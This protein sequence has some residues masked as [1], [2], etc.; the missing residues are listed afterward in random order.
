MLAW[1]SYE[2]AGI[3]PRLRKK[4]L[5]KGYAT[6]A[7]DVDLTHGTLKSFL[8]QR[9]IKTTLANQ[10]RLYAWGCEI[11]TWDKVRGCCRVAA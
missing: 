9:P 5:P 7:H 3:V 11:L 8:E 2:F 1:E 10:V 4:Q 6:V